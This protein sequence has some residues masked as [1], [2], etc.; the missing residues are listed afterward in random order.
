MQPT[1]ASGKP[2]A[3]RVE[4]Q[5]LCN[6]SGNYLP[7]TRYESLYFK[8]NITLEQRN[9]Q[10]CG[11]FYFYEGDSDIYLNLGRC[12]VTANKVD[13]IIKLLQQSDDS[14]P[15]QNGNIINSL[16]NKNYKTIINSLLDVINLYLPTLGQASN[17][18]FDNGIHNFPVDIIDNDIYNQLIIVLNFLTKVVYNDLDIAINSINYNNILIDSIYNKY[19]NGK[20]EY[21]GDRLVELWDHLDQQICILAKQLGYDTVILQ[22]EAGNRQVNTEILDTRLDSYNYLCKSNK[23]NKFIKFNTIWFSDLGFYNKLK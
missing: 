13:A 17:Y 6:L 16:I 10:F 4:R 14:F 7:V 1:F 8:N 23:N 21:V 18:Y 19:Q 3:G 2:L 5:N 22:R 20:V 9:Q 15:K 12:L 11:K